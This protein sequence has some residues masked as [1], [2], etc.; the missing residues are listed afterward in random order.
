M[1]ISPKPDNS[2]RI[3]LASRLISYHVLT[4]VCVN[5]TF[6]HTRPVVC[7]VLLA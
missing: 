2:P 1:G 5:A 3:V 6:Y 4:N 7:G